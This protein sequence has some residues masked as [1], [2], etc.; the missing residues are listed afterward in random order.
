EFFAGALRLPRRKTAADRFGDAPKP[1]IGL[2]DVCGEGEHHVIDEKLIG[3]VPPTQRLLQRRADMT[4]DRVVMADAELT[5]DLTNAQRAGLFSEAVE[6]RARKIEKEGVEWLVDH[7]ARI[8][9]EV[10]QICCARSNI[11]LHDALAALPELAVR[12]IVKFQ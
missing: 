7:V 2:G 12:V 3:L 1:A 9:L 5:G 8:A 6:R 11:R 4:D 10:V